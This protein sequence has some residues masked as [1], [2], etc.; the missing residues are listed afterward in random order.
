MTAAALGVKIPLDTLAGNIEI[1]VQPGTQSGATIRRRGEGM[2]HLRGNGKGDL[3]IHLEVQT[4]SKLDDAQREL[5]KQLAAL[6][7]ESD[8]SGEL[9]AENPGFF[10]RIKDAFGGR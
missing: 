5:I 3:V 6:R 1:E 9:T 4:P 10:S 8:F 2:P 7:G